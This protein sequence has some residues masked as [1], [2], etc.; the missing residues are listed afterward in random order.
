MVP[1]GFFSLI[2]RL[3]FVDLYFVESGFSS[4][5]RYDYY[6]YACSFNKCQPQVLQTLLGTRENGF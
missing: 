2:L 5:S 3:N 6:M 4:C 1:S